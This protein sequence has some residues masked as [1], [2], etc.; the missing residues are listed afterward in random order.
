MEIRQ[1]QYFI[2]IVR[3]KGFTAAAAALYTTQ[4]GLTKS[5]KQ[6]EDE[7]GVCL[8]D[9]NKRVFKLTEEGQVF[10][11]RAQDIC[12]RIDDLYSVM[13][14]TSANVSGR[15]NIGTVTIASVFFRELEASFS[16]RFPDAY[17]NILEMTSR[18][19]KNAV[20][21][22]RCDIGFAVLPVAE[23]PNAALEIK[24]ISSDAMVGV[25]HKEYPLAKQK[26]LTIE[27]LR[28]E[29]LL[30][31]NDDYQPH[32]MLMDMCIR[33]GFRPKVVGTAPRA[34]LLMRMVS[35]RRGISILPQPY[36]EEYL[37]PELVSKPFQPPISRQL[38]IIYDRNRYMPRVVQELLKFSEAY[39]DKTIHSFVRQRSEVF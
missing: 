23:K 22:H 29:P 9:R 36:I 15:V 28:D 5:I 18:E 35:N 16:S 2:E 1:L 11:E 39:F 6:L 7:L 3:R 8:I 33:H 38:A 37:V 31:F 27:D 32:Q 14:D 20:L 12:S 17:L 24:V 4:P 13:R 26:H 34:Y 25:M 19:I 10:Y 21:A 30:L